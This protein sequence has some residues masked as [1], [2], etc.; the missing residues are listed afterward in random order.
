MRVRV[1]VV[2]ILGLFVVVVCFVS[3][4]LLFWCDFG[5][6]LLLLLLLFWGESES[7]SLRSLSAEVCSHAYLFRKK[8]KK[9]QRLY[10]NSS[11][12]QLESFVPKDRDYTR[13][14]RVS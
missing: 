13:T 10:L 3:G 9:G 2:V 4:L 14:A 7:P 8:G 12:S 5:V 1:L 11:S 6:C